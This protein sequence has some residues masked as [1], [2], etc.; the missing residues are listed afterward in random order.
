M[1]KFGF[2]VSV[3]AVIVMLF[4]RVSVFFTIF[5]NGRI[6]RNIGDY[7]RHQSEAKECQTLY[8]LKWVKKEYRLTCQHARHPICRPDKNQNRRKTVR[9]NFRCRKIVPV[10]SALLPSLKAT[11]SSDNDVSSYLP[12][13]KPVSGKIKRW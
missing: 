2:V 6:G 11:I 4:C 7:G 5:P 1:K 3:F 12:K 9:E 13:Q 10:T 8:L